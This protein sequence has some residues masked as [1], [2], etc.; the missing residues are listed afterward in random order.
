MTAGRFEEIRRRLAEGHGL[1]EIARAPGCSRST[2]RE[3]RDGLRHS[4]DA[5]QSL[6]D[7]VSMLQ[8]DW[9]G[10]APRWQ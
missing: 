4:P 1:R 7:P 3:V 6:P 5:P 8:L 9:P 2:V 10:I